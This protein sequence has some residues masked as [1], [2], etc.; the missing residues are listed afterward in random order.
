MLVVDEVSPDSVDWRDLVGAKPKVEEIVVDLAKAVEIPKRRARQIAL[1]QPELLRVD[2]CVN[3]H[4][5]EVWHGRE[6]IELIGQLIGLP[7]Q[8]IHADVLNLTREKK[9]EIDF[10]VT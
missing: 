2:L 7:P 1:L 5:L 9:R 6:G 3:E 8:R 10:C 4:V